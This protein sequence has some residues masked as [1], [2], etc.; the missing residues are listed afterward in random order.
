MPDRPSNLPSRVTVED[1]LR[2]KRAERPRPEF[3]ED[4]E[5]DLRQRQLA[6]LVERKPWWNGLSASTGRFGWLRLPVGA[7]AVLALTLLSVREY[8]SS[9]GHA[10]VALGNK[11]V[12]GVAASPVSTAFNLVQSAPAAVSSSVLAVVEPESPR[13]AESSEAASER[14]Q[15]S[16][17]EVAALVTRGTGVDEMG[18]STGREPLSGSLSIDL[19]ASGTADSTLADATAHSIG[20]E[21]RSISTSRAHRTAEAL[22]TAVAVTEQR[23]TRLLAALGSAGVYAPEP[24]APEHAKRSVIRYLAEDGWDRSMSRLQADADRLSIRF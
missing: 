23:R 14:P 4:F 15:V 24:S 3:W 12:S 10:S 8:S 16:S 13:S 1:L 9:G 7:T 2:L 19:A 6:A 20:F 18:I 11:P 21:D 22:P 5:R 17:R